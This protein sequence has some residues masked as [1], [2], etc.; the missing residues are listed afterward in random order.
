MS[1]PSAGVRSNERNPELKT[2]S[3]AV[4]KPVAPYLIAVA[5]GEIKVPGIVAGA[6]AG[7]FN[8]L[9]TYAPTARAIIAGGRG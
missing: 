5:V 7:Y 3:F 4:N 1:A 9:V 2:F 8:Q 6:R